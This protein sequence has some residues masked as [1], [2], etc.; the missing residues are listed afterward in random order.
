MV[1]RAIR[2]ER[3]PAPVAGAPYSQAVAAAP[4]EIIWVSG[5]VPLD[6]SGS[7]VGSDI[8]TQTRQ[9]LANIAAILMEAGATMDDVVKTTVYLTDL[10]S[11]GE[12]NAVYGEAFGHVPP[13]RATV[14][15]S[16]LPAGATVEIEAI[17]VIGRTA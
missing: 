16:A 7:L 3:A 5:Q 1:R 8:A 14:E 12:M 15:V 4:G 6:R 10:S 11:F 2:T 9:C 17:A 13:A